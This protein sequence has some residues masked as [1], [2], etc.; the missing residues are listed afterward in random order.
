MGRLFVSMA[1]LLFEV[2]LIFFLYFVFY[3]LECVYFS[4]VIVCF[5]F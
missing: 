2:F 3:V 4:L 5:L 1:D